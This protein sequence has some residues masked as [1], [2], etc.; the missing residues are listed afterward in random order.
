MMLLL[1]VCR[2]V[3][4]GIEGLK[5]CL[6]L[7][8]QGGISELMELFVEALNVL[9]PKDF[10]EIV[11]ARIDYIYTALNTQMELHP[12]V[13]MLLDKPKIGLHFLTIMA[14]FMADHKLDVLAD[15]DQEEYRFVLKLFKL[16]FH[17][18]LKH[19]IHSLMA[20]GDVKA[21]LLIT[22]L[23]RI[24]RVCLDRARTCVTCQGYLQLLW[25]FFRYLNRSRLQFP[26]MI[27]LLPSALD[28]FL[29]MLD[30]PDLGVPRDLL[31]ELSLLLPLELEK[32]YA[33]LPKLMKPLLMALRG[34]DE[35]V[36]LAIQTME[37]WIDRLNPDFLEPALA[38]LVQEIN[39]ALWSHLKPQQQS[40]LGHRVLQLLGKL[41]GRNRRFLAEP[42]QL[43]WKDNPEH[44]LRLILVFSPDT[45]FLVPLDKC[46]SL[47]S[48][49]LLNKSPPS[50]SAPDPEN[51]L[52]Y[53]QQGMQF[54]HVCLIAMMNLPQ[55][56][57]QC[58]NPSRLKNAILEAAPLPHGPHC[59]GRPEQ[60]MQV[61]AQY[62]AEKRTLTS[63]ISTALM[64]CMD[65]ELK[66]EATVFARGICRHF[67]LLFHFTP[68]SGCAA[69]ESRSFLQ[70]A[71]G[72]ARPTNTVKYLEPELFIDAL[73]EVRFPQQND[74]GMSILCAGYVT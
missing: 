20:I 21:I 31:I 67:A 24:T 74:D 54:L 33:V 7:K 30:G 11:S 36:L 72:D 23:V 60:H 41:G 40:P 29:N 38:A 25:F 48:Q 62:L 55:I 47:T 8:M 10:V 5:M 12:I 70:A 57:N 71:A 50:S 45:K 17:T 16:L 37:E 73:I 59:G 69:G 15:P 28:L 44:G 68:A 18:L 27:I 14:G 6:R 65:P 53:R 35:L 1:V 26:E 39:M 64:L 61:K 2:I 3:K 58:S 52:Y 49:K 34:T 46:I 13:S 22:T 19:E 9:D 42:L 56:R 51:V 66:E 32:K 43:E 4:G 63:L